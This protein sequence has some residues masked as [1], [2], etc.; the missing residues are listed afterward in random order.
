MTGSPKGPGGREW[1]QHLHKLLAAQITSR[2]PNSKASTWPLS[3][4]ELNIVI[5]AENSPVFRS[6]SL[7]QKLTQLDH[8][9]EQGTLHKVWIENRWS[10]SPPKNNDGHHAITTITDFVSEK[11]STFWINS[12]S[13][14]QI[15]WFLKVGLGD[16]FL[17]ASADQ[18]WEN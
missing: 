11:S 1:C 16:D 10:L 9:L 17:A 7:F 13:E 14:I 15:F 18:Q 3:K 2:R 12:I 4:K 6:S 8:N 5:L